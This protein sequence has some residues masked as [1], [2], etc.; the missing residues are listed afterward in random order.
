MYVKQYKVLIYFFMIALV[1]ANMVPQLVL[2]PGSCVSTYAVWQW[3]IEAGVKPQNAISEVS[4]NICSG[5]YLLSTQLR[6]GIVGSVWSYRCQS[7]QQPG[8][9]HVP[10]QGIKAPFCACEQVVWN[11]DL[12][13]Q[14]DLLSYKVQQQRWS[15][16]GL[17]QRKCQKQLALS[18]Q[19]AR[20]HWT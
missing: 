12:V 3:S 6:A 4:A 13:Q 9:W 10:Q 2:R 18:V 19:V 8:W 7:P 15:G 16:R 17:S 20:S 11:A 1:F 5:S 14:D